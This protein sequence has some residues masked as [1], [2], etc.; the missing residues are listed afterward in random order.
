MPRPLKTQFVIADGAR[1][2]WVTQADRVD[3][4]VTQSEIQAEAR[5]KGHPQGAVFEGS[6]GRRFSVEEGRGA[7][8]HHRELFAQQIADLLNRQA[9]ARAFER[10]ALIAPARLLNAIKQRLSGVASAKLAKTLAKDLT[11]T[12][13]HE[14]GAWLRRLEMG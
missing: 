2:R 4:F 12:P 8:S 10:L 6:T 1:A 5:A 7:V 13:D 9:E 11:K 14:L 3:D